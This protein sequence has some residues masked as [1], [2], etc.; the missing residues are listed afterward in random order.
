MVRLQQET[1]QMEKSFLQQNAPVE[2]PIPQLPQ[3]IATTRRPV[4]D[5]FFVVLSAPMAT[6]FPGRLRV[7]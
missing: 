4:Q 2:A 5:S 6:G 1:L 7:G 3:T